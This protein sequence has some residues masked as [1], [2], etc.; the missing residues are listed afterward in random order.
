[1]KFFRNGHFLTIISRQ[2]LLAMK[3]QQHQDNPSFQG[4]LSKGSRT[5]SPNI[6][7]P[8]PTADKN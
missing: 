4:R 7:L 3:T 5:G 1:M 8:A 2:V 6:H